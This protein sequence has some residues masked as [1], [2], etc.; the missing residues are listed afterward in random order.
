MARTWEYEGRIYVRPVQRGVMLEDDP[1][2]KYVDDV[3]EMLVGGDCRSARVRIR[4]EV[5][6]V[7]Q[8]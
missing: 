1:E 7:E 2:E 8:P 3:I 6:D 4:V 5:L